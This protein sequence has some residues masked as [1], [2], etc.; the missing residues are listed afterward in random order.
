MSPSPLGSNDCDP[1]LQNIS[2]IYDTSSF[3]ISTLTSLGR[4][5]F[6]FSPGLS[7]KLSNYCLESSPHPPGHSF[8]NAN[9]IE[10]DCLNSSMASHCSW[11][12]Q[13]LNDLNVSLGPPS[14][15]CLG[16]GLSVPPKRKHTA[17]GLRPGN[18]SP[19]RFSSPRTESQLSLSLPNRVKHLWYLLPCA[20]D[21]SFM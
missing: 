14:H 5:P 16:P 21:F 19:D 15:H 2:T 4:P 12:K 20:P 7:Q 13:A 17:C 6:E 9:L 3:S 8:E 1:C 11:N 10:T 18:P